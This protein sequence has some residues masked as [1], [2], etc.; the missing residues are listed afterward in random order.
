MTVLFTTVKLARGRGEV[1]GV[2]ENTHMKHAEILEGKCT[3]YI[4]SK[5][6]S[7]TQKLKG[8]VSPP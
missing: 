4:Y 6:F 8:L 2:G 7:G 1:G 3:C 5:H